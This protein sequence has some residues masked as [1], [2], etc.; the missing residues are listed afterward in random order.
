MRFAVCVSF[1]VL[2]AAVHAE[3]TKGTT[4][5]TEKRALTEGNAGLRK[6]APALPSVSSSANAGVEYADTKQPLPDKSPSQQIYATPSPQITKISDLLA[7]QG[8]SFQAAIANQLFAPLPAYQPRA[9]APTYEVSAPVPSQLAYSEHRIGYQNPNAI[10]YNPQDYN[11]KLPRQPEYTQ[12]QLLA[13]PQQIF[14]QQPQIQQIYQQIPPTNYQP[15]TTQYNQLQPTPYNQLQPTPYNQ[16]QPTPYNQLQ[17]TAH[18]QLQPIQYSPQIFKQLESQ[19]LQ[20]LQYQQP[21]RPLFPDNQQNLLPAQYNL[22]PQQYYEPQQQYQ[23]QAYAQEPI[24]NVQIPQPAAAYPRQEETQQR[25]I[26]QPAQNQIYEKQQFVAQNYQTQPQGPVSFT[27]FQHNQLN[28]SIIH[29]PFH[30]QQA[31]SSQAQ[32]VSL[33]NAGQERQP[34][35]FRQGP[36]L[37]QLQSQV[38]PQYQPAQQNRYPKHEAGS[39]QAPAPTFPAVQYFGKYAQSIFNK[40]Q[41]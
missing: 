33:G 17:P 35:Y 22:A 27:S 14:N 8:P 23:Q 21:A 13:Q 1:V 28:P 31:Q 16:L 30:Q 32:E 36:Q 18:N 29:H 3:L 4:S 25:I 40:A 24:Q 38:Q 20:G 12:Q 2:A 39:A 15:Q 10:Q 41:H 6:R 34:S 11:I 19:Q 26:S 9:G 5:K 7:A 37:Q